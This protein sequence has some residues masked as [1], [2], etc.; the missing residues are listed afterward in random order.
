MTRVANRNVRVPI[1]RKNV[2]RALKITVL[3]G[4]PSAER[5]VS[6]KSGRAVADALEQLGHDVHI[7]DISPESL[8]ALDIPAD[9][10]FIALHGSFGE[11]GKLQQILDERGIPYCGSGAAA[12]ALAMDKVASK[13]RFVEHEIPTPSFDV[14]TPERLQKV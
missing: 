11:D 14:V 8:A 13:C 3:S 9:L 5:E 12:S 6:L 10:V 1:N 2:A 7:A 4:G